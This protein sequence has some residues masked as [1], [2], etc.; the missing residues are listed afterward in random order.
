MGPPYYMEGEAA[1]KAAKTSSG[2][3]SGSDGVDPNMIG[4]MYGKKGG[5]VQM[6]YVMGSNVFPFM[7]T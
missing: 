2:Y 7:F 4:A 1:V 5:A 6:A 3:S